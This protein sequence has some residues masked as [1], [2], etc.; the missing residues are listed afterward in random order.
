MTDIHVHE[1]LQMM[2]AA[3]TGFTR[4]SL[5]RA[6][7]D[8]FGGDARFTTC[9]SR[10][11]TPDALVDFIEARGKLTGPEDALRLDRSKSCACDPGEA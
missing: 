2:A 3:E 6:I 9:T 8:R 1:V 11:L 4:A 5:A 7:V 10:G